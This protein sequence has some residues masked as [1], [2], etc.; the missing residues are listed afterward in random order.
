RF[1]FRCL[2]PISIGGVL[3]A[4]HWY[5]YPDVPPSLTAC[6]IG[7]VLVNVGAVLPGLAAALRVRREPSAGDPRGRPRSR[8]SRIVLPAIVGA[9][10]AGAL[11]G[12]AIWLLVAYAFPNPS[13]TPK[14]FVCLAPAAL[15]GVLCLAGTVFVGLTSKVTEEDDREWWARAGGL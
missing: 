8:P 2:A 5:V 3:L 11:V 9:G 14:L 10:I 12:A 13:R 6:L 7:G 1:L 4:S 15:L